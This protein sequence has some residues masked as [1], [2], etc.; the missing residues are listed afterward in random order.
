MF[1]AC[2]FLLNTDLKYKL[3]FSTRWLIYNNNDRQSI[4]QEWYIE[5][6]IQGTQGHCVYFRC[7]NKPSNL[8]LIEFLCLM[9]ALINMYWP[10][11]LQT[12]CRNWRVRCS[13]A[14]LLLNESIGNSRS[15][16]VHNRWFFKM[17]K[18]FCQNITP[19]H[20]NRFDSTTTTGNVANLSQTKSVKPSYHTYTIIRIIIIRICR[21]I[22]KSWLCWPDS[23]GGNQAQNL[24]KYHVVCLQHRSLWM[25]VL[26]WLNANA[27]ATF[28]H[29]LSLSH[30]N[31]PLVSI[32]PHFNN[33]QSN[34]H[35]R[36][37]SP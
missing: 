2:S 24:S 33:I 15:G 7:K 27:I 37:H 30:P 23:E 1:P 36:N 26:N 34:S 31:T 14:N 10:Q 13:N 22:N 29:P 8:P 32:Q 35:G 16:G 6:S 28:P 9:T 4:Y 11:C 17:R 19:P 3:L 25:K 20:N 21:T 5:F 12:T 18:R